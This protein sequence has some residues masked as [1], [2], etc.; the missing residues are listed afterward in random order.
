MSVR[1]VR[2]RPLITPM[3]ALRSMD[4]E[5]HLTPTEYEVQ[6]VYLHGGTHSVEAKSHV[7][8]HLVYKAISLLDGEKEV[9]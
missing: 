7:V 5:S 4:I 8:I 3:Q 1:F 9:V 2:M 6:Y